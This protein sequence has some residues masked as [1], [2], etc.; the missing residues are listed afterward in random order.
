MSADLLSSLLRSISLPLECR[1]D[2]VESPVIH[3]YAFNNKISLLYLDTLNRHGCLNE[4]RDAF[5]KELMHYQR[6]IEGIKRVAKVLHE[7]SVDYAVIK[8]IRPYPSLHGDIDVLV[9]GDEGMYKKAVSALLGEGYAPQLPDV[10]DKKGLSLEE[11]ADIL[12]RPTYG[13]GKHGLKHISPTGTDLLDTENNVYVDLQKQIALSYIIY[14][15]KTN[16]SRYTTETVLSGNKIKVPWPEFDLAIII[17]HSV[18]E[19]IYLLGEFCT[20]I[21]RTISMNDNQINNFLNILNENKINKAAR[22]FV[23]LTYEICMKVYG[24]APENVKKIL[25]SLGYDRRESNLL[26]KNDFKMPHRYGLSSLCGVFVEK[27]TELS[28]RQTFGVQLIKAIDPRLMRLM[29]NSFVDM[30]T[31]DRYQKA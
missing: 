25:S 27:L 2:C 6:I 20:F 10:I 1:Q 7:N 9:L 5:G 23:T 21:H 30:R 13:G 16:V 14:V 17:A 28:F 4:L 3:R 24:K 8:T 12:T 18:A 29:I 26:K 19:Q 11:K 31:R 22:L 15:N